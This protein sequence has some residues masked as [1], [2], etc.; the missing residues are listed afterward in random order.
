VSYDVIYV[1]STIVPDVM[2]KSIKTLIII[3]IVLYNNFSI[4]VYY[5]ISL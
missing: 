4:K 2:W 5:Q 3:I 1:V